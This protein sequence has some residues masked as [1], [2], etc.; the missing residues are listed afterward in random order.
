MS[1]LTRMCPSN[2]RR[3]CFF[4]ATFINWCVTTQWNDP[5]AAMNMTGL[6]SSISARLHRSVSIY[7]VFCGDFNM[8]D[9]V[10]DRNNTALDRGLMGQF[11]QQ[12]WWCLLSLADTNCTVYCVL[13]CSKAS[14]HL[15][16]AK[17]TAITYCLILMWA[18]YHFCTMVAD[19][20]SARWPLCKKA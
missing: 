14:Q 13:P 7:S 11:K 19:D 15:S 10:A 16:V 2:I 6:A 17:A 3:W 9:K 18:P 1:V 4:L 8:N 20:R 12:P 5:N